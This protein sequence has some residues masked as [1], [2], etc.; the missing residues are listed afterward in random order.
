LIV[1]A[2]TNLKV[3]HFDLC[4]VREI[5]E[6]GE[7]YK[8]LRENNITSTAWRKLKPNTPFCL[9]VPQNTNLLGEFQISRS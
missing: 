7:N 1:A 3:F 5:Y 2:S 4:G 9:F 8:Y 6:G